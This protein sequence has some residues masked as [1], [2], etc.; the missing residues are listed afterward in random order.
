LFDI[1]MAN[2]LLW[3]TA[4]VAVVEN[5][6]LRALGANAIDQQQHVLVVPANSCD[7]FFPVALHGFLP[8][9]EDDALRTCSK[10]YRPL[11]RIQARSGYLPL[12]LGH[13]FAK[14]FK[15]MRGVVEILT[16]G[17]E[18]PAEMFGQ[19]SLVNKGKLIHRRKRPGI[20]ITQSG[21]AHDELLRFK[22]KALF[23]RQVALDVLTEFAG[24]AFDTDRQL[25]IDEHE[26][27]KFVRVAIGHCEVQPARAGKTAFA[28][29]GV[30][31]TSHQRMPFQPFAIEKI[32][33]GWRC[34]QN[35]SNIIFRLVMKAL[36]N[37]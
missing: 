18:N 21:N 34:L 26:Y 11:A 22:A 12:N 8:F 2:P 13:F 3:G 10:I 37:E 33:D 15:A 1:A 31:Q 20:L 14:Q 19:T 30:T 6:T 9:Q 7:G 5:A 35:Q 28:H 27:I 32:A 4:I 29:L 36:G 16:M 17:L 24:L 25:A 23:Q